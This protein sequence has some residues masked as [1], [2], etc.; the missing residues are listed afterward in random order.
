MTLDDLRDF[1]IQE[2]K[3]CASAANTTCNHDKRQNT[4]FIGRLLELRD[5]LERIDNGDDKSVKMDISETN[6]GCHFIK[7]IKVV[8]V[9]KIFSIEVE[10]EK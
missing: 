6:N 9:E 10:D 3:A 5:V 2:M 7:E 1:I 4:L 8:S